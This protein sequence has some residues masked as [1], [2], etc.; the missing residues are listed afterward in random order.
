MEEIRVGV[1]Q[2]HRGDW[3]RRWKEERGRVKNTQRE[4][5]RG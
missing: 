5:V 4:L 3:M 2:K 1:R